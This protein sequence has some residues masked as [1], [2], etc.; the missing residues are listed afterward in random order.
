MF[1]VNQT[2]YNIFGLLNV[3]NCFFFKHSVWNNP[4]SP[5]WLWITL[6]HA[7]SDIVKNNTLQ[8]WY[9]VNNGLNYFHMTSLTL[10]HNW[11]HHRLIVDDVIAL[12]MTSFLCNN[13]SQWPVEMSAAV[14]FSKIV[15]TLNGQVIKTKQ[16]LVRF[17]S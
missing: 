9:F 5:G 16:P 15:P 1:Y 6:S 4:L 2:F 3:L 11:W 12:L 10:Q 13:T 8:G 14:G 17:T 7:S